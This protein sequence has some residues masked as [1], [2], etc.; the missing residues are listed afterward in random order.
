MACVWLPYQMSK[1]D[2]SEVVSSFEV[3]LT[4]LEAVGDGVGV[5]VVGGCGGGGVGAD[6]GGLL[7]MHK[8]RE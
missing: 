8:N 7:K 2:V 5:V 4:F 3:V 6:V 1:V